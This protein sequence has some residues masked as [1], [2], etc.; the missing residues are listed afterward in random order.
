MTRIP[1]I[2]RKALLEQALSYADPIR[3]VEP[4]ADAGEG[5][6]LEA[7]EKG[8][9]GIIAKRADSPYASGRS[10]DWLKFKC[11][12]RQEFVIGGYTEPRGTRAG[13]GALLLGYYQG[14]G[15]RYAGKVGTGFNQRDPRGASTASSPGSNGA[16]SPFGDETDGGGAHWVEPV[17]VAQ[18]GFSEWTQDGRLRHPRFLGLRTDKEPGDVRKKK[19]P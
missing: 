3:F 4:I 7:C 15:L 17:L 1:L 14:K 12:N 10:T 13:F 6:F 5:S 19:G 16:R 9:E 8:W 11:V 18:V 2:G